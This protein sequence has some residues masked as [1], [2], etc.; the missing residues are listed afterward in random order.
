MGRPGC[1]VIELRLQRP[2]DMFEMPQTD[3]F[4]EYRNFL[5]GVELC[6]S[7][8]RARRDRRPIRLEI[9]LPAEEI[10]D[11]LPAR[12]ART[13]TRQMSPTSHEMLRATAIYWHFV[14]ASWLAVWVTIWWIT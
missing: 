8:L 5:T 1:Q 14:A 4:S 2:H 12:M 10:D 7:E 11:E 13:L 3:L 6:V 9:E